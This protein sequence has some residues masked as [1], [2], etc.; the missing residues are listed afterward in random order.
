MNYNGTDH[1]PK[2][3]AI[4]N[5]AFIDWFIEECKKK[6][7][8]LQLVLREDLQIGVVSGR[9]ILSV[10]KEPVYTSRLCDRPHD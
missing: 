7:M 5:H 4:K 10:K 9:L 3:D 2:R 8:T 1:L 6:N